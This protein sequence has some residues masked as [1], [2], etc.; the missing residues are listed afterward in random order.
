[1]PGFRVVYVLPA[2]TLLDAGVDP[3]VRDKA[4][5]TALGQARD[6]PYPRSALEKAGPKKEQDAPP[7]L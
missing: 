4:G 5:K 1:M 6:Y 2:T 7:L 3:D